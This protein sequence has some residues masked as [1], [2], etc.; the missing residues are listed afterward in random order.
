VIRPARADVAALAALLVLAGGI[1]GS[2][3]DSDVQWKPDSLF[4]RSQVLRLQGVPKQEALRRVFEGPL[5]AP[6][7]RA[8]AS[9]PPADRKVTSPSWVDYSSRFYE[10][11]WVVPL[12][13]A[14]FDP[15]LGPRGLLATSLLGYVLV[16]A[17][18]YLLLRLWFPVRPALAVSA[19]CLLLQPVRYW[20]GLP[21]TDSWGLATECLALATGALVLTR[22][23][24][25]L[26]IWGA[27]VLLLSFTRDAAAIAV[28]GAIAVWALRRTRLNAL[29]VA[30][31]VAASLPA[32]LLFGA[33]V[34]EAIAY[35]LNDFRPVVDP[36]WGFVA[37]RYLEGAHSL[38]KNN[39]EWL[40]DHPVEAVLLA[41]GF[42]A[43]ALLRSTPE[44]TRPYVLG[45][46]A[47]AAVYV[48]LVPNYTGFRLELVL[49]PFAALGLGAAA[50]VLERRVVTPRARTHA[51]RARGRADG[52]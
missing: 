51:A 21:L 41:G 20:S 1:A 27:A 48:L 46:A 34:R 42:L 8:E 4:Y 16:A 22:G 28:A 5:A 26:P 18:L 2:L 50:S 23:P 19:A 31:G 30:T 10:R 43:L 38:V 37:D 25:W 40:F 45:A 17:F 13:A 32:P 12:V 33:P 36:S 52:A 49:V 6:R 35:T 29:L 9:L 11:R 14:A 44:G 7:R 39:L 15:V 47:A 3:W 24:R